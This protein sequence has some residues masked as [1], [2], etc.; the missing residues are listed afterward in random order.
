[1]QRTQWP[2]GFDRLIRFFRLKPRSLL[3]DGYEGI[4]FGIPSFDIMK[5]RFEQLDCAEVSIP[6]TRSH[7]PCGKLR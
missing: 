7:L 6:N 3:I 2:S 5:M 1:M 4:E